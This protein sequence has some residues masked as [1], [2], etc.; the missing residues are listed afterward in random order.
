MSLHEA[1]EHE[2]NLKNCSGI[3]QYIE[4]LADLL[5]YNSF[6]TINIKKEIPTWMKKIMQRKKYYSQKHKEK[7]VMMVNNQR[8][9]T[10]NPRAYKAEKSMHIE[11]SFKS[12][13]RRN[14]KRR[15][16]KV[17]GS[18]F[19]GF[20]I[21]IHGILNPTWVNRFLKWNFPFEFM[22]FK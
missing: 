19:D 8:I 18:V 13:N 6:D 9:L 17:S 20:Y 4:I 12:E 10:Q 2:P 15:D 3:P 21:K 22:D 5:E 16:K 14:K 1:L 7:E 11:G